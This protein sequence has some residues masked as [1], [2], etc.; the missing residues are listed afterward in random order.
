[1]KNFT[2]QR[3]P[4]S[5]HLDEMSVEEIA[6][7]MNEEDRGVPEAIHRAIPEIT[8][9]IEAV[10]RAFKNEGRLIYIGAGTSGRLGILDAVECVPTFGTSPE[11]VV[12]L[13]AGGEQAIKDAVEGA[14]DS[15]E[16]AIEDL[17][18]LRLTKNDIV[19]GIAASGR[20]PYV[21][22][23][24]NYAKEIGAKT[25][26]LSNN[27]NTK[28]SEI[29]DYPI[30]VITGPEVLT[31]STR[32]KAGTAQK[33]V[34]NMITTISMVKIGKAYEN[35]MVD[36]LATNEK[37]VDRAKRIIV[38]ATGVDYEEAEK[39]FDE[40]GSVK[41][42]IVM[43]LSGASKEDSKAALEETDGFVRASIQKLV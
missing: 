32:L 42:A 18:K 28:I 13:I 30:E 11:K 29:A 22:G 25:G 8:E 5:M 7:L 35:L 41:L 1:M 36:V 19:V 37:L 38:E 4:N 21:I 16:L 24:L 27:E 9:L 26:S 17:K 20:T 3:N 40:A 34:L 33:I 2:E 6:R 31:G 23:G 14:E 15:K 39:V 43:I 12:G 10:I